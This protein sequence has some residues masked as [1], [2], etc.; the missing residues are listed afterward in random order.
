MNSDS[1]SMN[2]PKTLSPEWT[3]PP[4][5][6]LVWM[7]LL[8][9]VLTFAMG[10]VGFLVQAS[11]DSEMFQAGRASLSQPIGM[12]N[13]L[14]LL[15]GGWFMTHVI[16][17]LRAG[18]I[19]AAQKWIAMTIGSGLLFLVLKGFE[20]AGK[21]EHGHTLNS[22]TFFMLY[23][24]LTGFHF[25]HVAVA[26]V[27]LLVMRRGIRLGHYTQTKHEDV[28]SSGIFWHMCDLI[29]LLLYPVIYL[30]H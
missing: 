28:E 14:V 3:E 7:I 23:W 2:K 8:V 21:L 11:E 18:K 6:I 20:Y 17:S 15:T 24:L 22:D 26:V 4:G 25:V 16:S 1:I 29:W 10:L 12:V 5:G 27:I 19:P 9:E 30:L 13:T